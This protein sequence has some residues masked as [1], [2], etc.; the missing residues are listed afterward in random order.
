MRTLKNI[1]T[2]ALLTFYLA[3]IH[4]T[5]YAWTNSDL[6]N[7]LIIKGLSSAGTNITRQ[8]NPSPPP[9]VPINEK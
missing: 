1:F 9:L 3:T 5:S 8:I 7:N 4:M 2:I 6:A